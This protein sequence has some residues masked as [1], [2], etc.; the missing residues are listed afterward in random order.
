MGKCTGKVVL[1]TGGAGGIGKATA[2]RV[3]HEGGQVFLVDMDEAQLEKVKKELGSEHVKYYAGDVSL[4]EDVRGYTRSCI[5]AYGRIDSFFC[6]AGIEGKFSSIEE[7]PEKI[8]DRVI[9][10]NLKGVWLGCQIVIP[11]MR[12]GGSVIITSS[13]AGLQGFSNLGAYVASKHGVVGI[14]RVAAMEYAGRKIR[15]NSIHP[16]PVN[17][18]MIHS[19]ENQ[20]APGEPQRARKD[21]ENSTLLGRYAENEEISSLVVFLIADESAYITGATLVIDGGMCL[22]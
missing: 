3:L 19:V 20:I 12:D 7:Y 21:F 11:Q 4:P 10:V 14:M 13:V 1:I 15:V 6:N 16:G 8:F 18:R 2:E 5:D 17:N 9:A 22:T